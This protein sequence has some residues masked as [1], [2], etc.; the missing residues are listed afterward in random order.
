MMRLALALVLA[1]TPMLLAQAETAPTRPAS[2]P[3]GAELP[4]DDATAAAL[5]A[6]AAKRQIVGDAPFAIRDF[7]ADLEATIYET[8]RGTGTPVARSAHVTQFFR[9]GADGATAYRSDRF[10]SLTKKETTRAF[11][12][13]SHWMRLGKEAP[14]ELLNREDR[15]DRQANVREIVRTKDLVASLVLRDLLV[16]GAR[17]R[18]LGRRDFTVAGRPV[19]AEGVAV[20]RKGLPRLD[21][22]VAGDDALLIAM[23]RFTDDAP[24][25]TLVMSMHRPL[26][27][28]T[29]TLAM[30]QV[31]E[32]F[33]NDR[34]V[35]EVRA[36]S[37]GAIKV[38]TGIEDR[39]FA[40][41]R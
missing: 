6:K 31:I 17:R 28:G 9:V 24:S 38:N 10:E 19:T 35:L 22:W 37:V 20:F 23:Q 30:P 2:R 25:E 39:V 34:L 21:V 33:E 3:V 4:E 18:P 1:A 41:P 26:A 32:A 14:R 7:Q 5:L 11:D 13:K 16:D 12:G 15:E 8:D 36:S 40:L 27:V 29:H